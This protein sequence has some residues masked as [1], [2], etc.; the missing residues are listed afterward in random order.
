MNR[1]MRTLRSTYMKEMRVWRRNSR[2]LMLVVLLPLMFW[3]GFSL[4]MGGVYSVGIDAALVVEEANPGYYTNGLIEILGEP[5][6]I[7]PSLN[8]ILMTTEVAEAAI[9]NG[10]IMLVIMI[11][12]GFEAAMA[13]NES[14]SIHIHVGNFAE[15]MTKNLRMPVIRKLDIYYQTYLPEAS[16]VDFDYEETREIT[17][18][19]LAYM[20]W[21]ISIYG[22]MFAAMYIAGSTVTQ[23]FEQETLDEI[24]LSNQ[25]PTAIYMGK[26]LSGVSLSYLAVPVLLGGSLLTYGFWPQ[27]DLLSYFLITIPLAFACAAIGILLGA[28]F[29]NSVY[30]VPIAA[31]SSV[32]YWMIGGGIAPLSLIGLGFGVAD[33]YSP[34]SNAYRSLIEM[35]IDGSYS[36]L[37]IDFSVLAGFAI[38]FVIVFPLLAERISH[39]DYSQRIRDIRKRVQNRRQS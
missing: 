25:S 17:Y 13:A 18:P 16:L 1:F 12:S 34:I 21:T 7:P 8:L 10:D 36:T 3:I 23:E 4:L 35:F 19:R 29:R 33:N 14:T 9:T 30:I 11:P 15:D 2:Q 38:V 5:D 22:V 39:V 20:A 31:I 27:G 26:M 28:I 24:R 32:F 37:L 6:E